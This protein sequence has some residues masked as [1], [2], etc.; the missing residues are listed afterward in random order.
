[1]KTKIIGL[2]IIGIIIIGV[3]TLY[4]TM[5]PTEKRVEICVGT[6]DGAVFILADYGPGA[7]Y[8]W[9]GGSGA[10][11]GTSTGGNHSTISRALFRFNL[12]NWTKGDITLH[13][14][15]SILSGSP[16]SIEVYIIPD[17][18]SLPEEAVGDPENPD[19]PGD[20]SAIWN[21]IDDGEKI[22]EDTL[23]EGAW[24]EVVIPEEKV[25]A[26]KTAGGY[27]AFMIKISDETIGDDNY[28]GLATYEYATE[29][30]E[31]MPYISWKE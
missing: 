18:D 5:M 20:V 24:L 9:G 11:V 6:D 13:I 28:Y 15:C 7:G 4:I 17:F 29:Y 14:F 3:I 23:S 30:D 21:L 22:S 19:D 25:N 26:Y 27:I 1:M 12:E 2:L 16:G 8:I 31:G 10:L